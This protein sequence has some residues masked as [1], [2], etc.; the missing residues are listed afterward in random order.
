MTADCLK[1]KGYKHL[2]VNHSILFKDPERGAHTN[3]IE[4]TWSAIKRSIRGTNKCTTVFDSYLAECVWR[5]SN[6]TNQFLF[7]S[8]LRSIVKVYN[9]LVEN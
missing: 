6:K 8:F 2:A 4:G 5:R 3:I 9:S 1:D 7:E